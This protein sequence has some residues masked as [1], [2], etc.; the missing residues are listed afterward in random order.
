MPDAIGNKTAH[1]Y[2]LDVPAPE[3]GFFAKGLGHGD[4][5]AKNRLSHLFNPKSGNTVMLAFDHGYIMGPTAGLERIDVVIPPL[6][7]YVN[8]LMGTKGIL[9]SCISPAAPV[10]KCVRVTYD[11]TV[12]FDE[13]SNGGGIACDIENAVR[14]NADCMAVQTFIGAPGES[15]SLE[16]LARTA[17]AG[18]RYGIP[19]LGVVAVGKDME[20][21]ERFFQLATRV[22][23]ENGA[24]VVKSYYCEGFER[25][26]A[27]C[28]VPIVIVGG[29]KLPEPEALEMAYQAIQEGAHGVD[30]GRNIFQ[31]DC[32]AGMAQAIAKV[33]HEGYTVAQAFEVYKTVKH[34]R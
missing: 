11:T 5:G 21:T 16:L 17:D 27:A 9:R 13:M 6:I 7:P 14:M 24:N 4:W 23:A 31:S 2:H 8:V 10:A 30:M 26:A 1:D 15:R 12:L 20:R 22:L 29:K 19:T 33:V 32:P 3:Q 25:V 34:Q 18:A 28:P